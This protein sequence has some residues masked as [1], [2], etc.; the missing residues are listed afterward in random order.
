MNESMKKVDTLILGS[1]YTGQFL[2][3]YILQINPNEIIKETSRSNEDKIKF[4]LEDPKTWDNLPKAQKTFWTFPATPLSH[5]ER[6]Y[7][8]F[9]KDLG[10]I[11]VIGST[12]AFSAIKNDEVIN[13]DSKLNL[14][15]N[16]VAGEEFLRSQ[17][18]I[19]VYSSGI[20]GPQRSP[21]DWVRKSY[22]GKSKK[23]INLIH[24]ED[25]SQFLYQASQI[26]K[27]SQLYIASNNIYPTWV[28][29][30]DF[31]E[32]KNLVKNIPNKDSDRDSKKIN[33]SRS[34]SELKISLKHPNFVDSVF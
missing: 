12:S 20:Y 15:M 32:S 8:Q 31:W 28:E 11:I 25:L 2:K 1:G 23:R 34:I 13:E 3:K 24:V 19:S 7:N 27:S 30:I 29:V 17:G 33:S 26:G 10:K 9:G 21:V 4:N 14:E 5:V 18:A 22:V 16:R 6:F